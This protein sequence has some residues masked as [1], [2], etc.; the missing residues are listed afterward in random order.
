M[1]SRYVT[2]IEENT[3]QENINYFV[4]YAHKNK[5]L[6]QDFLDR[7]S[8][9]LAPSKSYRYLRWK[10]TDLIVG[11][12][13]TDQI[14]EAID[15]CVMGLLLISPAFLA[16]N[17]ITKN[18]LPSFVSGVKPSVPV[19]IQPVDFDLHDLKGLEKK[20]IFRF[21]YE[22]FKEP[23]AYGEC[24]G[25]RRDAFVLE[26]FRKIEKK[27][28]IKTKAKGGTQF[29][30]T[31]DPLIDLRLFELASKAYRSRGTPKHFLDS[32]TLTNDQRA[33]L[34]DKVLKS[35]QGRPLKKN[36]YR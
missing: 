31:I 25:Q 3:L 19:M 1:H 15:K 24:K 23:K 4:S 26:L 6:A 30:A 10:D 34:Y 12:D 35:Q 20:Q 22:G 32:Q 36:P 18:E 17:Y 8:D 16:S 2:H 27:L 11:E 7:L 21:E 13:W 33:K 14:T 5:I 9:V 29:T 28:T